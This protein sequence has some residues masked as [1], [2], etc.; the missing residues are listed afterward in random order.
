MLFIG[1]WGML[2]A[3][4]AEINVANRDPESFGNGKSHSASTENGEQA[5]DAKRSMWDQMNPFFRYRSR[6]KAKP[7]PITQRILSQQETR[8]S[9][10]KKG[11][12]DLLG[13]KN[14][15]IDELRFNRRFNDVIRSYI[16]RFGNTQGFQKLSHK[17]GSF[18]DDWV[19]WKIRGLQK[20]HADSKRKGYWSQLTSLGGQ[21]GPDEEK[22]GAN[23]WN[24]EIYG[25]GSY[26]FYGPGKRSGMFFDPG[27]EK[28]NNGRDYDGYLDR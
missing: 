27:F 26:A 11:Y 2:N 15:D 17:R 13:Y 16:D 28:R 21:P 22:D 3:N 12:L 1:L 6:V 25:P 23:V 5:N 20:D 8:P 14:G 4:R 19:M 24:N 7:A 10:E 18:F 9:Y